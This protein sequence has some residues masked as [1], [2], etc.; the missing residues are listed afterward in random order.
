MIIRNTKTEIERADVYSLKMI[1]YAG[2]GKYDEAVEI[3]IS[4]L[5][6]FGIN[7]PKNPGLYSNA[8]ELLLYKW[9]MRNKTIKDLINLPEMKD[10]V[11][12]IAQLYISLILSAC[13]SHPDLYSY[14]IIKIG[15]HGLKYGNTEM[16]SIGFIGYAITEGSVLGNYS[17]G[18]ELGEVA[19]EHAERFGKSYTNVLYTLPWVH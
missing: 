12:K 19:I 13:T 18:Y 15:N 6:N 17:A 7:I 9:Y 14:C 11:Q 2:G 10:P 3:G 1:L 16:T 5:G 4:T 8:K